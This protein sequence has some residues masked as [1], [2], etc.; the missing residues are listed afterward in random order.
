M[1]QRSCPSLKEYGRAEGRLKESIWLS[2]AG[3]GLPLH[4]YP[5]RQD[6][7]RLIRSFHSAPRHPAG[8]PLRAPRVVAR[9]AKA[10]AMRNPQTTERPAGQAPLVGGARGGGPSPPPRPNPSEAGGRGT[11]I[12]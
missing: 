2:E 8:R 1:T 3:N 9:L 4:D 11:A 5:G 12:G 10:V 7:L 6:D